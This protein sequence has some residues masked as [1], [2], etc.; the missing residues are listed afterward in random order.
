MTSGLENLRPQDSK[1]EVYID[2]KV[3]ESDLSHLD[4][5]NVLYILQ[6]DFGKSIEVVRDGKSNVPLKITIWSD[7]EKKHMI[8]YEDVGWLKN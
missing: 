3:I 7:E 4:L 5:G 2:N 8:F 6:N 1:K